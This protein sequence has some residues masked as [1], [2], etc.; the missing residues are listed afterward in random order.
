MSIGRK[1]MASDDELYGEET[2]PNGWRA[3]LYDKHIASQDVNYFARNLHQSFE[4]IPEK[5][6]LL[7]KA[8]VR[9]YYHG[10]LSMN[11]IVELSQGQLDLDDVRKILAEE[12][13]EK[14][15]AEDRRRTESLRGVGDVQTG[16]GD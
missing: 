9:A 6:R 13:D 15:E 10:D 16:T 7:K 5:I 12:E 2:L 3:S 1:S 4:V 11:E 8:V 14:T